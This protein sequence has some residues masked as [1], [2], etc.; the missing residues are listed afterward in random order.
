MSAHCKQR[1]NNHCT[2]YSKDVTDYEWLVFGISRRIKNT[3]PKYVSLDDIIQDGYMGAMEALEKYDPAR[4]AKIETYMAICIRGR[5]IDGMRH[6]QLGARRKMSINEDGGNEEIRKKDIERAKQNIE[7]KLLRKASDKEVASELGVSL[8]RYKKFISGFVQMVTIIND[9]E[10]NGSNTEFSIREGDIGESSDILN[11][12]IRDEYKEII[13]SF[14]SS[15]S[16][17]EKLIVNLYLTDMLNLREIGIIIGISESRVSQI[18][19]ID[20][21]NKYLKEGTK[22]QCEF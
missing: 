22:L 5:I 15:L 2:E 21:K 20:I 14:I 4:G 18:F 16:E 10:E 19:R 9:D 17:R 7:Q 13:H 3:L 1:I 8:K 11:E 12:I 6:M